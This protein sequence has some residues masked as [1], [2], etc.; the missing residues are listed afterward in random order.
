MKMQAWLARAVVEGKSPC[1]TGPFGPRTR[2]L[3]PKGGLSVGGQTDRPGR[4]WH[5][6]QLPE[7]G[8]PP[9]RVFSLTMR[10]TGP[11]VQGQPPPGMELMAWDGRDV[12]LFTVDGPDQN[13]F[14]AT[15]TVVPSHGGESDDE[16]ART[17]PPGG[18]EAVHSASSTGEFVQDKNHPNNKV[19]HSSSTCS[20]TRSST[21][22]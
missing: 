19:S 14:T 5:V 22:Q 15:A 1:A 12:K 9:R 18:Q 13:H 16:V 4:N 10:T 20:S 21:R 3:P 6:E 11:V 7:E 8:G 17:P 2:V